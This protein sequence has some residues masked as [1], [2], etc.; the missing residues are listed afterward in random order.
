LQLIAA[1]TTMARQLQDSSPVFTLDRI[2]A[3]EFGDVSCLLETCI[4]ASCLSAAM[5]CKCVNQICV[6]SPGDT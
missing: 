3:G 5:G 2:A 1:P 6:F 4:W